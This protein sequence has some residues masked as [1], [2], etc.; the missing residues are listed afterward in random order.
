M[1]FREN[2]ALAK[3]SE[4]YSIKWRNRKNDALRPSF[5]RLPALYTRVSLMLFIL[6]F[7]WAPLC[8]PVILVAVI[9]S[10]LQ[11]PELQMVLV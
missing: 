8:S 4:F 7:R 11:D 1:K 2:K 5:T 9:L 10:D 3:I 6:L